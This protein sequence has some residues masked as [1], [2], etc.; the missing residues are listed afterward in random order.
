MANGEDVEDLEGEWKKA[1]K[2]MFEIAKELIKESLSDANYEQ[3]VAVLKCVRD[4]MK[5]IEELGVYNEEFRRLKGEVLGRGLGG[6]RFDV[7]VKFRSTGVG[8]VVGEEETGGVTE[9]EARAFWD[10]SK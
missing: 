7:W 1:A 2:E 6:D 10:P 5:E 3:A 9:E 4:E 8:L